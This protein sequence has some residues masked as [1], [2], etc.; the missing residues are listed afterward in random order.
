VLLVGADSTQ[1]WGGGLQDE[2]GG[3]TA[4]PH[5]L[6]VEQPQRATQ[7]ALVDACPLLGHGKGVG[8]G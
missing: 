3:T 4:D 5:P 7:F 8:S 1:K 6:A 2:L